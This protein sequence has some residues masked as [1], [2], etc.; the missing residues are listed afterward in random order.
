MSHFDY[1]PLAVWQVVRVTAALLSDLPHLGSMSHFDYLPLGEGRSIRPGGGGI[2]GPLRT[3]AAVAGMGLSGLALAFAKKMGKT[4]NAPFVPK[5]G[6]DAVTVVPSAPGALTLLAPHKGS[7]KA[8]CIFTYGEQLHHEMSDDIFMEGVDVD[9][10]WLYG[11]RLR[12]G[13]LAHV[14]GDASDVLAGKV[15][16]WDADAF[17]HKLPIADKH[18]GYHPAKDGH[19]HASKPNKVLRESALVVLEDGSTRAAH[20]YFHPKVEDA[21]WEDS[22]CNLDSTET[23]SGVPNVG[24]V[25]G[26]TGGAMLVLEGLGINRGNADLLRNIDLRIMPK[27]RWGIV[28]VNGAG[29][30]TLLGAI[31]GRES[32]RVIAGR[33]AVKM[34]V[35]VGYL[36]QTAVSGSKRTVREETMSRMDELQKAK[37][38]VE[39]ATAAVE[40]GDYSEKA[41]SRLSDAQTAYEAAGGYN[42]DEVVARVLKGLGFSEKDMERSCSD[43]S[44]G[45]QMRIALARLLLSM[46]ELMLL[47]EPTNHLDSAA[48]DWLA[49]YLQEFE[50]TLVL[51]SHDE[52][53]LSVA[54]NSIA[55]VAGG[56]LVAY[57]GKNLAQW[58]V[59]R[60]ERALQMLAAW[61]AHQAEIAELEDFI[62]RFGAKA[63]KSTQAKDREKKLEKL[64]KS[65]KQ[66]P[67]EVMEEARR[68]RAE[69]QQKGRSRM[70]AAQVFQSA[71]QLNPAAKGAAGAGAK[72]VLKA[73]AAGGRRPKNL[74][75]LILPEPP[76]CGYFPLKLEKA[77]IGWKAPHKVCATNVDVEIERD[78]RLVIRGPN[79]AGKSTL[80]KALAGSSP[81][82]A[83][84]RLEDDRLQIGYFSQDLAQDLDQ[85]QTAL[86]VVTSTVRK[87]DPGLK[88]EQVRGVL[89]ALGLKGEMALRLVGHLSGGE[90]A[91]VALAIFALTPCNLYILDEPSNHLDAQAIQG[92]LLALMDYKGAI[93][94]V[95]HDR[96][97]C[98][99]VGATHV[100]TVKDGKVR[101]EARGLR[102]SDWQVDSMEEEAGTPTAAP[103]NGHAKD[104]HHKATPAPKKDPKR[105]KKI[106]K[107]IAKLEAEVLKIDTEM[108][109]RPDDATRLMELTALRDPLTEKIAA[110]YREWEEIGGP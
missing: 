22:K 1:L 93:V 105:A 88:D 43:F 13:P 35:R 47:D 3:L 64:K 94:I 69:Q 107:E 65:M 7:N 60:A 70:S 89:G 68:A 73:V 66:P 10:A 62:R 90:K 55:E 45:W 56:G 97:F 18:M 29:K 6:F 96:S 108:S 75:R 38:E 85:T 72:E 87:R 61:E 27:E 82:L 102:D 21:M 12:A 4:A 53:L 51:V 37:K 92:L 54:C 109:S 25:Y 59:S 39:Q 95:S 67:A 30:S 101:V 14:T 5:Q 106:E 81:L 78:M 44:G 79:G 100:A 50:G 110:C 74:P 8:V 36:E 58:R 98:E 11:A 77:T 46:P 23:V 86:D 76:K 91:R 41:L 71:E 40:G 24:A 57:R 32:V 17:K 83:G 2:V 31:T 49:D 15:L 19:T 33:V 28:G 63:S 9:E 104:A 16:C 20:C 52:G 80:V 26:E 34:G 99:A 48:R 42:A 103:S 84:R